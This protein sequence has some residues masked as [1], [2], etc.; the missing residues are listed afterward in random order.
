MEIQTSREVYESHEEPLR[1]VLLQE[2]NESRF[3]RKHIDAKIKTWLESDDGSDNPNAFGG[4][5]EAIRA[6]V[7]LIEAWYRQE[8]YDSKAARLKVLQELDTKDL[9]T[10]L[11]VGLSYYRKPETYVT[12]AAQL[13]SRLNFSD[14][15]EA[16]ISTAELIALLGTQD[17]VDITKTSRYAT[18]MVESRINLPEELVAFM[19]GCMVRPPMVC[20]PLELRGDTG[21]YTSG[22]LTHNDSLLLGQGNHHD[23]DLCLDALNIQNSVALRI[24]PEFLDEMEELPSEKLVTKEQLEQWE[25]FKATSQEIYKML[26]KQGNRFY[27]THKVDMRGRSYAQGYHLSTMGTPFK[28]AML[29]LAKEEIVTGTPT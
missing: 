12:V 25:I 11:L 20:K 22:Y 13:A 24:D 2:I 23:G 1:Q 29:E 18:A 5:Q 6:A 26:L 3:S 9:V 19:D 8:H 21:N 16:V 28:K 7:E 27:F 14:R 10:E 17:I 15:R 4:P